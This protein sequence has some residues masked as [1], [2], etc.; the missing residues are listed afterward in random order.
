MQSAR[1]TLKFALCGSLALFLC[2]TL[3]FAQGGGDKAK[4][5]KLDADWSAASQARNLDKVLS[6]YSADAVLL[7]PMAPIATTPKAIHDG[8]A[9]MMAANISLSWKATKTEIAKSGDI[10]YQYGTYVMTTKDKGKTTTEKGKFVDVWKK[11]ADG[12]WKCVVDTFNTDA[13]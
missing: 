4:L 3:A 12:S 10:A 9:P 13:P 1:K 6:F 2:I 11:Q 7:P 8:W 5:E